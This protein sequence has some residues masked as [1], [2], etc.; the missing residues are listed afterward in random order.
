[1]IFYELRFMDL[2]FHVKCTCP[3]LGFC[4]HEIVNILADVLVLIVM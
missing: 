1:M 2:I 4:V 3:V